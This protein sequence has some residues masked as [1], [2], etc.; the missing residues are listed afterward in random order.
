MISEEEGREP[1]L[2]LP[3]GPGNPEPGVEEREQRRAW[4][5][6]LTPEDLVVG[7]KYWLNKA[8]G[9]GLRGFFLRELNLHAPWS[10]EYPVC[11][12]QNNSALPLRQTFF[13][14]WFVSN[15]FSSCGIEALDGNSDD[16]KGSLYGVPPKIAPYLLPSLLTP[17]SI[18]GRSC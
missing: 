17:L 11:L 1:A 12:L 5:P 9:L 16:E 3:R 7:L 8:D 10:L 14:G 6:W 15:S 4:G 13:L 18:K 2:D